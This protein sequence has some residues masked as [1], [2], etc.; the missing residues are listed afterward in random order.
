MERPV[1]DVATALEGRAAVPA[2]RAERRRGLSLPRRLRRNVGAMVGLSILVLVLLLALFADLIMPY[3]PLKPYPVNALE[4]PSAAHL[5][6]TDDIGR[7]IFSRVIAGSRI[8][9]QVALMVLTVASAIGVTL[10]AIAGYYGGLLDEAIMRLADVFFAFPHFLLAMAIVAALGPGI[11]NAMLAIAIVYWPRYAR[12]VRGSILSVKNQTYV[13][14]A[15]ALGT[16]DLRIVVKHILPNAVAPL[17]V[18][19]TMDAGIAILTT[20]SLSFIGLGAVPPMAEWGA[21]V[22]QGRQFVT[23]AWWVP[24]FP[25][26]AISITVAGYVFLGDGLRDLLDPQLRNRVAF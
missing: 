1:A 4:P 25:G 8:S 26:L 14:A 20:A 2:E 22:A 13:E 6:G 18:Q 21:M 3:D 23:S 16:T 5:F 10:G 17:L 7:D 24:A 12:L 19:A 9:F 15:R 11:T